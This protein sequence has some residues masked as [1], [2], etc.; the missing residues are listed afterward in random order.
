MPFYPSKL[1]DLVSKKGTPWSISVLARRQ[2]WFRAT[3]FSVAAVA[4]APLLIGTFIGV[5]ST[6]IN[7]LP[8]ATVY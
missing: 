8:S 4:T 5:A 6:K 3:L 2:I 1:S 7:A